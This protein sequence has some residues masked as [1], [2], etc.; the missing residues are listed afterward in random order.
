VVGTCVQVLQSVAVFCSV[1]SLGETPLPTIR[2]WQIN[3]YIYTYLYMNM[4]VYIYT[5]ICTYI[6]YIYMYIYMYIY[7][8]TGNDVYMYTCAGDDMMSQSG[9]GMYA[10]RDYFGKDR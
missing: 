3:M 4:Y 7:T 9:A 5:Y 6:Y 1:K 8:W 2:V 10:Q